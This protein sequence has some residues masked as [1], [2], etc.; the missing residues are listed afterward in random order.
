MTNTITLTLTTMA[1]GGSAMG[2]DENGRPVFVPFAIPGEQVR[3][4]VAEQ[5]P[6][7]ARAA[8]LEVLQ[9]SAERVTPRCPHFGDCGGCHFQHMTY[10]AQL[11]VIPHIVADQMSR[12]GGLDTVT[13]KPPIPHDP[14]WNYRAEVAL[15]PVPGGGL[16]FWSPA[17]RQVIP[18]E[19]CDLIRTELMDCWRDVD[20]ELPELRKLTLRIGDDDALLAAL[21]VEDVEPPE[22]SVDFPISVAIVLP[23]QTAASLVGDLYSVQT[24]GGRDFRVSPGCYFAP[25]TAM[26]TAVLTTVLAQ[27]NLQGAEVVLDAYC[28]V[29]AFTAFLA[30]QAAQVIAVEVNEDAVNDAVANLDHL[31]NVSLYQGWLEEVLPTLESKPDV[32]VVDPPAK[33]LS[34]TAVQQI[35][36]LAPAKLIYVSEDIATL[37]RDSKHFTRAGYKLVEIQPL[38]TSPQTYHFHT[39][40]LWQR[41]AS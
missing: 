38:D 9:P 35:I 20:L 33:G 6:H 36:A 11:S 22:L 15:S 34:V 17:Q 24:I 1:H 31:D 16:G 12:I 39:V 5:K 41:A 30:E 29:G 25:N 14:V 28:G 4:A 13:V 21:E 7:Y 40:S 18:I 3:A 23:D 37:A 32:V 19:Q 10:E 26:R 8:L 27:A 2:F